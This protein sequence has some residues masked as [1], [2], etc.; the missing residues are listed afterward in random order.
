MSNTFELT[1]TQ[2]KQ[3]IKNGGDLRDTVERLNDQPDWLLEMGGINDVAE[4]LAIKQDGCAS[5]AFMPAVTY[6]TAL[7][8]M[9]GHG[10]D[11]LDYLDNVL[12]EIPAPKKGESWHGMAAFYLSIAVEEWCQQFDLDYLEY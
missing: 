12:G 11:V 1:Y 2:C 5:G 6:H 7:E 4:L 8:I 10:G 3:I 9:G